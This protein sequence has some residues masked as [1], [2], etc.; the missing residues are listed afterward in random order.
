MGHCQ[1]LSDQIDGLSS[2]DTRNDSLD[3]FVRRG[4]NPLV[5]KQ[6]VMATKVGGTR[7]VIKA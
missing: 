2:G 1:T 3:L 7:A 4:Y 5:S 6:G